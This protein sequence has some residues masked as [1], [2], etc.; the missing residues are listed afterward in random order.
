MSLVEGGNGNEIG[1]GD[2]Q[3]VSR[4]ASR[5]KSQVFSGTLAELLDETILTRE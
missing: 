5:T 4:A 3:S 1:H 2:S